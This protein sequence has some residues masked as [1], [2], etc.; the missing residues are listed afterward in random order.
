V[1]LYRVFYRR[2][3]GKAWS[4]WPSELVE[5]EE[6]RDRLLERTKPKAV[7]W[8]RALIHVCCGCGR[9]GAWEQGW[10]WF[11]TEKD[12]KASRPIRKFCQPACRP[13]DV[14]ERIPKNGV[15]YEEWLKLSGFEPD[16]TGSVGERYRILSEVAQPASHRKVPMPPWPGPG[17]C[18]WCLEPTI[19]ESG[20]K[21]G[22]PAPQ[23]NWHNECYYLYRLHTEIAAQFDFLFE[24][25]GPRCQICGEGGYAASYCA[26]D[27]TYLKPS[28]VLEVDHVIPLWR[29]IDFGGALADRRRLFGPDNLWLLCVE[30]HKAKTAVEAAERAERN[31]A[32]A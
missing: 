7:H 4:A 14:Q 21:K 28:I 22:Q 15:P 3:K 2:P 18:R 30:C 9:T 11:G 8:E 6:A 23:R 32:I 13:A 20:K 31:R 19:W 12:M 25:D 1:T 26:P 27:V 5:G 16:P 29:A 17:S 24:R 10:T